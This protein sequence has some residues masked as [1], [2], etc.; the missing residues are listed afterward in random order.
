MATALISVRRLQ[1][2]L[3]LLPRISVTPVRGESGGKGSPH[4]R[5]SKTLVSFPVKASH[6]QQSD[7]DL[8]LEPCVAPKEPFDNTK[9]QNLQHFSYTPFTFVDVD[10]E[11]AKLRL[12]QPSSGRPSPRH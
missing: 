7:T 12:P 1:Q 5:D 11:L 4:T 10:V 3:L 9:Y 8:P 2:V 6:F